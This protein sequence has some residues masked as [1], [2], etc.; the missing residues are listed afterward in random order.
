MMRHSILR[1]NR[2]IDWNLV[3][4][5]CIEKYPWYK[6][7][8]KQATYVKTAVTE[9]DLWLKVV[10]LDC[11][12]SADILELNGSVHRDS[13]FEFFFTPKD[14]LSRSYIHIEV[15]CI[16]TVYMASKNELEEKRITSQQRSSILIESSLPQAVIKTP[17]VLD[18]TWTLD[19]KIPFKLIEEMYDEPISRS[20]WFGNLYR[21]GGIIDP[22]YAAWKDIVTDTPDFHQPLQFGE[23]TFTDQ[24][25]ASTFV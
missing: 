12:S 13:C 10:A 25:D 24:S 23:F 7:G 8:L 17:N 22:Q 6:H 11:H 15:N 4:P 3:E 1:F 2:V 5:L 16:G 21:C 19:I 18:N 9:E 20:R 14:A